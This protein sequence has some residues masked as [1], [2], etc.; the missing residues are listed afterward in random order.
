M[1]NTLKLKA[2]IVE[3]DLTNEEVSKN[4][5]ISKQSFSMKLNNKREFKAS[6]LFVLIQ[7]LKLCPNEINNIFFNLNVELNS[8][9][10]KL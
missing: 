5:G 8:T 3:N 6:E 10:G 7:I 1:I 9:C 2:L 4:L